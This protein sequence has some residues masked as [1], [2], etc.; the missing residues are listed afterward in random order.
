MYSTYV[1]IDGG[2]VREVVGSLGLPLPN[3]RALGST[4]TD[5]G[6]KIRDNGGYTWTSDF[7]MKRTIYYDASPD[8][9]TP[10]SPNLEKY[11]NAIELLPDTQLGF[12]TLRGRKKSLRQKGVDTLMTVQMLS[13]VFNNVFEAVALVSGD[14][15]FVPVLQEVRRSGIQVVLAAEESSLS[16]ELRREADR[17]VP[18]GVGKDDE[19]FSPM[20]IDGKEITEW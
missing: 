11:W 14:A 18:L 2:Y 7:F 16:S 20:K 12:G 5:G 13:G 8:D 17:F 6:G 3:P 10:A 9:G 1:F 4:V 15:D 19:R